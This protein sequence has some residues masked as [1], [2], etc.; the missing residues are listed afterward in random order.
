M[1]KG[2]VFLWVLYLKL[3]LWFLY[4]Y[5]QYGWDS[6][7]AFFWYEEYPYIITEYSAK[8]DSGTLINQND[9]KIESV[10]HKIRTRALHI[11]IYILLMY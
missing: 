11:E 2:Y 3:I 4:F 10:Y 9:G 8:V 7:I 6:I 1:V 5:S